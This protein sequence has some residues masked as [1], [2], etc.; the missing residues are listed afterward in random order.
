MKRGDER[1]GLSKNLETGIYFWRKV[2]KRTGQRVKRST[3]TTHFAKALQQVK[4]FE[5]ELEREELG[6]PDLASWRQ[7][8]APLAASY[9][10]SLEGELTARYFPQKKVRL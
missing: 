9:L 5:E 7:E 4:R 2:N 6:L 10:A 1:T 8:L 3:G